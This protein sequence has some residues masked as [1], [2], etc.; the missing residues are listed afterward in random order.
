MEKLKDAKKRIIKLIQHVS[1]ESELQNLKANL[2]MDRKSKLLS[3][4]PFVDNRRL[5]HA[6][7]EFRQRHLTLLPYTNHIVELI[8]RET[9][10]LNFA[11]LVM[12]QL[13]M[14]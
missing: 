6:N 12:R 11:M 4:N 13:C 5:K 8:I 1:F 7:L 9:H 14:R 10:K 3:L 2:S